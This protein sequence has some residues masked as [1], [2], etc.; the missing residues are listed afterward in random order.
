VTEPGY[1]FY[2]WPT[3]QGRG[4]FVRLLLE[5]AGAPYVDVARL[6]QTQGGGAAAIMKFLHG[7]GGAL[8]PFAPP[9]LKVGDLVIAQTTNILAYLAPKHGL[10]PEDEASRVAANQ[11][12]LTIADLVSEAHDTHHPIASSLYYADQKAEAERRGSLFVRDRIHKFLAY[13]ERVLKKQGGDHLVGGAMSYVD[14]CLFQVLT[15]LGYAF[16]KAM[17]H[18][19]PTIPLTL[20]LRDRVAGRPGVAEYLASPRRL[21]FSENDLFRHYPELDVLPPA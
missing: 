7:K 8:Q 17:K 10:V 5:E 3:I 21:P 2:Y 16:P 9:F 1:E 19:A 12:A 18:F 20:S 13:F 4:E 15:G 11:L 14:L 6:P